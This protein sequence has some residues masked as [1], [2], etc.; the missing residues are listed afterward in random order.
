M[1]Q[2]KIIT[3]PVPELKDALA[4]LGKIIGRGR[5]TLPVL[6][7]VRVSR[8]EAGVVTLE[9]TDLES[10]A[11]F[12]LKEKN[13]G[14]ASQLLVPLERLQ[15]AVKQNNNRVELSP[16]SKEEITLRTFWRDTP[17]EEKVRV[18]SN[19]EWPVMPKVEGERVT[20]DETFRG[21]FKEAFE[22]ASS[23]ESRVVINSVYL[24]VEDKKAH[25]MVSTNG[26]IL[27]SANSFH[28]GLKDSL[29]LPTRKFL[30]W[31]GWWTKGN[32]TLAVTPPPNDKEPGWIKITADQWTFITRRIDARYPVWRNVVPAE[33]GNTRIVIPSDAINTMLEVI[34]RLPGEDLP[35]RDIILNVAK[36]TLV[37][38]G[39]GKNADK[40]IAVPI[41]E[42]EVKGKAVVIA[43]NR[44]YLVKALRFGLNEIS[45]I[46][47]MSPLVMKNGG[48]KMI[49]MPIRPDGVAARPQPQPTPAV[50][51]TTTAST[52]TETKPTE[53]TTSQPV[54]GERKN[55]PRQTTVAPV[56]GEHEQQDSPL[57]QLIQQIESIK[58]T[59]KN[60]VGDLNTALDVVKK[61]EKEKRLADKEI[62]AIRE[63]VRE[64]QSVSI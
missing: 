59:L 6:S 60:V 3:L 58:T 24:D 23:D 57:K 9:A 1:K 63:K 20:L 26:R 19:E 4:G 38:Q 36:N 33:Q 12:T 10:T 43:L 34:A 37:L 49:I 41:V 35:N 29:V 28:F 51:T 22:C 62:E 13:D 53:T 54:A 25:Y 40:P 55:M 52:I 16:T 15:K 7:S 11:M 5:T 2:N 17:M 30:G 56:N 31:N 14:P 21:T 64:I 39:R 27:F 50:P 48:K 42:A 8:H 61:A 32:A 45:I 47:E 44:D 18:P 46:D